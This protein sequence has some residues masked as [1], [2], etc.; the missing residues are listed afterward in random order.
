M[1]KVIREDTEKNEAT[2]KDL[3]Y[4]QLR[5][6]ELLLCASNNVKCFAY[7]VVRIQ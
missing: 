6:M 4:H 5:W 3:F 1:V 2:E 7:T